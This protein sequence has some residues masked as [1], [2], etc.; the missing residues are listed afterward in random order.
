MLTN[1]SDDTSR[2]Y[3]LDQLRQ[4]LLVCTAQKLNCNKIFVADSAMDIATKVLDD[5]CLGR[6]VQLSTFCD[7]Q[8][9]VD[10]FKPIRDFTQQEL[11]YYSE[12][13]ELHLIKSKITNTATS[14]QALVYKFTTGLESQF[15]GT[16]S[17]IFRTA[18][19]LNMKCNMNNQDMED[20]CVLCNAKLDS[21][22]ACHEVSARR[23]IEVSKLISSKYDDARISLNDGN[24]IEKLNC[25]TSL[26]SNDQECYNNNSSKYGCKNNKKRQVTP[27]DIQKCLC[28]SCRLIFQNSNTLCTLPASL[29]S[30]VRQ[31]SVL[32]NMR[33]EINDYLL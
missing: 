26:R 14:I 2:T 7:A 22:S 9:D 25:C 33:Q 10:I 11:V 17:T 4:K 19:K 3:L 30:A 20:N 32:K 6:G 8:Y 28:Y 27:K 5:I 18:E 21:V 13:H 15:S 23:A 12:C 16:V 1:L 29:L 24:K 31:K